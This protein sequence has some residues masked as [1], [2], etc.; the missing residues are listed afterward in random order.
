MVSRRPG[1]VTIYARIGVEG[2]HREFQAE[3][4]VHVLAPLQLTSSASLLL[5][6]GVSAAVET[7][8]D[9]THGANLAY[10]VFATGVV[11]D[12]GALFV[13]DE[14][15]GLI[16]AG[17]NSGDGV[18]LVRS[19]QG[20]HEQSVSV[21]TS[22]RDVAALGA[23]SRDMSPAQLLCVGQNRTLDIH[24]RDHL[25]RRFD[26]VEGWDSEYARPELQS[27]VLAYTSSNIDAV[28]IHRTSGAPLRSAAGVVASFELDVAAVGTSM[29]KFWITRDGEDTPDTEEAMPHVPALYLRVDV[30][31]ESKCSMSKLTFAYIVCV[32]C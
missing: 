11:Y 27:T 15:S 8:L 9:H 24:L 4:H 1:T 28:R 6:Y 18:L 21:S 19:N 14:R 22:V 2:D 31:N 26:S 16:R 5:P 12:E 10:E 13:V 25:G 17:R 29:L 3:Y 30:V 32:R 20:G 23:S 7:T